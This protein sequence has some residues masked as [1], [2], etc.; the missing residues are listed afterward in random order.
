MNQQVVIKLLAAAHL[1]GNMAD[2]HLPTE[3]ALIVHAHIQHALTI[4]HTA[5]ITTDDAVRSLLLTAVSFELK[6]AADYLNG[7][8]KHV[9]GWKPIA[10]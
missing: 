1:I 8:M 10:M 4:F 7:K 3:C 9:T 5:A 2:V 6:Y